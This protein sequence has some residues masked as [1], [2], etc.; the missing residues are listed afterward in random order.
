VAAIFSREHEVLARLLYPLSFVVLLVLVVGS[1]LMFIKRT[2]GGLLLSFYTWRPI[3][4]M[5]ICLHLFTK[6]NKRKEKRKKR[7]RKKKEEK[8]EV[9]PD[10]RLMCRLTW[11]SVWL[12]WTEARK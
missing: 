10:A 7:R 1:L 5:D 4:K 3:D 6:V 12:S 9:A 11:I 2:L 8:M